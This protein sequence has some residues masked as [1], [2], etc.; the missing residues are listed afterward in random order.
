MVDSMNP[1]LDAARRYTDA[2]ISTVPLGG[3]DGKVPKVA[4]WTHRQ[5]DLPSPRTLK[6][7]YGGAESPRDGVTGIGGICGE[8]SGRL[9]FFELEAVAMVDLFDEFV[10]KLEDAAPGLYARIEDGWSQDSPRGGLHLLMRV[11]RAG[12]I[13]GSTKLAKRYPTETEI[14]AAIL[15]G[16]TPGHVLLIETKGEG[17]YFGMAPGVSTSKTGW[18][19]RRGGPETVATVTEDELEVLFSVARTFNEIQTSASL[20]GPKLPADLTAVGSRPG[21]IFNATVSWEDVLV[22]RREPAHQAI[23]LAEKDGIG[24]W[25][26]PGKNAGEGQSGTTNGTGTDRLIIFSS[27]WAPFDSDQHSDASGAL[28]RT[29]YS[30]FEAEA[31]LAHGGDHSACAAALAEEG[32]GVDELTNLRPDI[33]MATT[34]A[35][36]LEACIEVFQSWLQ[37]P[38]PGPIR[39]VAATIN[40]GEQLGDPPLG[41][42]L[43][44]P[45]S[46]G[47]TETVKAVEQHPNVRMVSSIASEGALLSGTS[48][49]E[50]A[51][52]AT[53]GIL[54]EIGDYGIIVVKD[55]TTILSMNHDARQTVLAAI[56]E[57][58]DG[59]WTRDVGTDGGRTL[60]WK[61]HITWICAVTPEIDKHRKVLGSMGERFPSY[62][63]PAP[64]TT[65]QALMAV[66][67]GRAG[68]IKRME[69]EIRAAF[70]QL[71]DVASEQPT[72]DVSESTK[73][74]ITDLAVWGVQ[75]RS[76][77]WRDPT[78]RYEI[79]EM[80]EPEQPPRLAI[81]L[82]QLYRGL[83]RIGATEKQAELDILKVTRDSIPPIR[84]VIFDYL[85]KHPSVKTSDVGQIAALETKTVQQ[86]LD[87]LVSLG[88]VTRGGDQDT[89]Y[90]WG[91]SQWAQAYLA[92]GE[93]P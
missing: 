27:N 89:G 14:E 6:S 13:E 55:F 25:I 53:G 37:Y 15:A 26:R 43:I 83:L 12:P 23:L 61:G 10:G 76:P 24:Y 21:D 19:V 74:Y 33:P 85:S 63:M 86:R 36:A 56:R 57:I 7:D 88:V 51:G 66:S 11:E 79:G 75:M 58:Q 73:R 46:S 22:N 47:K 77:V 69:A 62:R 30:K 34:P 32:I 93:A 87:E 54:A 82:Q 35:E 52:D 20:S 41:L 48:T 50:R 2:G 70:T 16:K 38:D 71:L 80:P 84:V 49:R 90:T 45:P 65:A 8:V 60:K 92:F 81:G 29:S 1:L 67:D 18:E 17:G 78:A 42:F 28:R 40:A 9:L 68:T 4:R 64:D 91:I 44:G 31:L 5:D 3:P 59:S 39:V 72:P